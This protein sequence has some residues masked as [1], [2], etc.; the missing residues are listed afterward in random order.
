M[1][2]KV[3]LRAARFSLVLAVAACSAAPTSQKPPALPPVTPIMIPPA[4][5]AGEG[6]ELVGRAWGWQGTTY[7]GNRQ[8]VPDAPERYSLHFMP[9]GHVQLR[10]DCNRG[11]ARYETGANR[12]LSL[13]PAAVTKIGCPAGSKDG[14]FLRQLGEVAGYR[15]VD[16]DLVLALDADEGAMRFAPLAR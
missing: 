4:M 3:A 8:V 15:F 13:G 14:E 6:G 5:A 12:A 11:R 7:S 10:A 16:G 1:D 2:R 9:D